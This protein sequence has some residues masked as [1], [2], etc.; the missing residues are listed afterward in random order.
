[1]IG[2]PSFCFTLVGS[3]T[4]DDDSAIIDLEPNT[5]GRLFLPSS[6]KAGKRVGRSPCVEW[7]QD[8]C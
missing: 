2:T 6:V 4:R 1:M 7:G 8:G 5:G 3:L